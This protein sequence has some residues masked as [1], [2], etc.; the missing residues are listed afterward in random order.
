[1]YLLAT[2]ITFIIFFIEAMFHFNI[3]KGGKGGIIFHIPNTEESVKIGL[4]V[5]IFSAINTYI[6]KYFS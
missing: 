2:V 6:V 5:L 4:I 3:G 1:M